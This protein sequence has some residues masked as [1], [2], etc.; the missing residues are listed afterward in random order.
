MAI[1]KLLAAALVLACVSFNAAAKKSKAAEKEKAAPAMEAADN[2]GALTQKPVKILFSVTV[3]CEKL[4]YAVLTKNKNEEP[5][6][7]YK[8][9]KEELK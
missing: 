5:Q 3:V 6:Q 4:C 1:R 2:S 9:T 8:E 7:Q